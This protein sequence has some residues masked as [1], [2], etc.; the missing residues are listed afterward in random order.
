MEPNVALNFSWPIWPDS[1]A[2]VSRKHRYRKALLAGW[3]NPERT[4]DL[5]LG[6]RAFPCLI[7]GPGSCAAKASIAQ[8]FYIRGHSQGSS[9]GASPVRRRDVCS[10]GLPYARLGLS[11]KAGVATGIRTSV[12]ADVGSPTGARS[13]R[14][15]TLGT[16]RVPAPRL[17]SL[18]TSW[19]TTATRRPRLVRP[20]TF[21]TPMALPCL[22]I[23]RPRLRRGP[24][25]PN[26]RGAL[27]D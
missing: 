2:E 23:D 12:V 11:T 15:R 26:R 7:D 14:G 10:V 24:G 9:S 8:W 5:G 27:Q 17:G 16:T 18:G 6:D 3:R 13:I 19:A 22:T 4:S 21:R 25:L 20:T 1:G